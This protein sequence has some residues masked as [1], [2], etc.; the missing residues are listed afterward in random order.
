MP[1]QVRGVT[2]LGP[3]RTQP[4]HSSYHPST[5]PGAIIG[6]RKNG[7]PIRLVAGGDETHEGGNTSTDQESG[8]VRTGA[9]DGQNGDQGGTGG[10]PNTG[11]GSSGTSGGTAGDDKHARTI[12]AIRGD[13]KAERARRQALGKDLADLKTANNQRAA[14]PGNLWVSQ[15]WIRYSMALAGPGGRGTPAGGRRIHCPTGR[16]GPRSQSRV[17]PGDPTGWRRAP[18]GG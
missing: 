7:T 14:G 6:Y 4:M 1:G 17:L 3:W 11:T 2:H 8:T 12:E 18:L 16:A 9:G 15:P 10:Q 13:F 5:T